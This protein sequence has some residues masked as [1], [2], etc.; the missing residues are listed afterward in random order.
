LQQSSVHWQAAAAFDAQQFEASFFTPGKSTMAV[1]FPMRIAIIAGNREVV[2]GAETYLRWVLPELRA[3]GHELALGFEQRLVDASRAIERDVSDVTSWTLPDIGLQ[4]WLQNL[5]AFKPDVAYVHGISNP[6]IEA[7]LTRRFN[8]IF[9][10]HAYHGACA[11]GTRCHT[12]P[13]VRVCERPFGAQCLVA[14][15]ALGCG[16]RRPDTLYRLYRQQARRA[17]LLHEYGALVVA[18]AYVKETYLRQGLQARAVHVVPYPALG[19]VRDAVAPVARAPSNRVLF[20]GRVTAVKGL[21]DA[22]RATALAQGWLQRRLVLVV[23]GQGPELARSAAMARGLG[24]EVESLG[25]VDDSQKEA[26]YRRADVLLV[27]SLWAEPFGI[28]GI[29]AGC[30]GLPSV[31]YPMGGIVDWLIPGRSGELCESSN[32]PEGL[33]RALVK[34]LGSPE[35]WSSLRRGAWEVAGNYT[36]EKHLLKLEALF[37]LVGARSRACA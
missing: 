8:A 2:G 12:R 17:R 27:P 24:V 4:N 1:R 11:T 14:N 34:A 6:D 9:Y 22:V 5:E 16:A 28:V 23:A 26:L 18:S 10:A 35:H 21:Q 19:V 7:A 30:V 33:A 37:E 32:E 13:R 15:F 29:E 20:V 31:G 36:P 25:W 3:R